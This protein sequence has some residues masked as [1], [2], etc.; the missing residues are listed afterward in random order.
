[1]NVTSIEGT[2][3]E[4]RKDV[5]FTGNITVKDGVQYAILLDVGQKMALKWQLSIDDRNIIDFKNFWLPPTTSAIIDL[6][7]GKH[8]ISVSGNKDD[9]P[10]R[11][12][13]KINDETVFR[14]PVADAIDYVVFSGSADQ[15]I[16]TYRDLSGKAPMMPIWSLGYIH[17]R[18]R[19]SS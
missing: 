1:M 8:K 9:Y 2:K 17:C 4:V 16:S 18:E 12:Y 11:Y 19:F 15:V 14:S 10:S 13:H 5:N 6:E 3:K 7:A